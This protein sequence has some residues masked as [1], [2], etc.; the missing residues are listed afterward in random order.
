MKSNAAPLPSEKP[1][2]RFTGN[3]ADPLDLATASE[4]T[5][6]YGQRQPGHLETHFFGRKI[7][8]QI[9]AQPGCMGLRVYYALDPKNNR[10]LLVVGAEATQDDQLP[11][12]APPPS[13]SSKRRQLLP[14]IKLELSSPEAIIAQEAGALDLATASEWTARYRQQQPGQ[15]EAYFFGHK[16]I[17]QILAQPDCMGLRIYYALDPQD[18]QHLLIVGFDKNGSDPLARQARQALLSTPDSK[19]NQQ[20]WSPTQRESEWPED[21]IAEMACPSPPLSGSS[22]RLNSSK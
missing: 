18:V 8:E 17:E 1:S 4:W 3:E 9:L 7:I 5:A 10:H 13:G 20:L 19:P 16:I 6:R 15:L 14:P 11:S 2:R 22:N 21:I 12:Q